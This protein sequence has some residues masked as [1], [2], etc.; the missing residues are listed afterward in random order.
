MAAADLFASKGYHHVS[1]REIC[2]RAGVSKPVLYYYFKDKED[3]LYKLVNEMHSKQKELFD[4]YL[5][6][7]KSFEGKLKG[8]YNMYL[9][10]LTDYP[11]LIRL[12]TLVHFSPLPSKIKKMSMEKSQNTLKNIISIFDRG[13]K[14]GFINKDV[15]IEI[16]ALSF[17]GPV[18]VLLT[19]SVL[20]EAKSSPLEKDLKKFFDFWTKQFLNKYRKPE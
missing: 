16:I 2:D 19:K 3:L 5:K 13:K 14:E 1:V 4:E 12:S 11:Y 15:D 17:L 8:L 6:Q 7:E 9:K 20:T 18:G 10:F